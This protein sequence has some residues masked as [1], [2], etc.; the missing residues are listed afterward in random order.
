MSTA[1]EQVDVTAQLVQ[2]AVVGGV[3]GH[4]GEVQRR[5][6]YRCRGD[7]AHRLDHRLG[8]LIGEQLLRAVGAD[9]PDRGPQRR[10]RVGEPVH[11]LGP[12]G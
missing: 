6:R 8:D 5:G 4:H 2:L 1:V 3:P 7:L 11:Q 10:V 12:A 9:D